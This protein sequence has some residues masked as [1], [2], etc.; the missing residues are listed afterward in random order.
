M[1]AEKFFDI[2]PKNNFEKENKK[3]EK[4]SFQKKKIGVYFG[5]FLIVGI[6][7]FIFFLNTKAKAEIKIYL[8][9]YSLEK[10]IT[11]F[12]EEEKNE[13]SLQERTI[14]AIALEKEITIKKSYFSSGIKEK[15]ERARGK[16][17]IY[18]NHRPPT[19]LALVKNTRF[20]SAKG[21]KIFT[22]KE[23][24]YLPP[25]KIVKGK[26]V[27]SKVTVEVFAK[28]PGPDYN[29]PPSKFS[30]P[31]L[32][33]TKFYY[34]IWAESKAKMSGGF[35]EKIK[36]V[37]KE[38]IEKAKD[39]LKKD[40][41]AKGK[42]A[43]AE[44][45]FKNNLLISKD[46]IFS[47]DLKITCE[48]SK[49]QEKERFFCKGEGKVKTLAIK[50][51][52][53]KEILLKIFKKDIFSNEELLEHSLSFN[54]LESTLLREKAKIILTIKAKIKKLKKPPL[55]Y[56]KSKITNLEKKEVKKA[57]E[58]EFDQIEKVTLKLFPFWKKRLPKD[59]EKIVISF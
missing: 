2:L 19:S 40:F 23:R 27:P 32:L 51:E 20:L 41:L 45:A 15:K 18:N 39:N 14:P 8:R 9:K 1:V 55:L 17:I 42:E 6:S 46:S 52:D 44:E 28:E 38:D 34:S 12:G 7:F 31:G 4:K 10:K 16:I 53:L 58:N 36:F 3:V 13:I 57:L 50:K 56:L 43:L 22:I 48:A 37:K 29:I 21:E 47:Q 5:I 35:R 54:L 11:L 30:L 59:P 49:N 24:V 26:I 25:A 33:G